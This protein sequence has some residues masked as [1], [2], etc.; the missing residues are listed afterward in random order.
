MK[1]LLV[2]LVPCLI[3]LGGCATPKELKQ[4]LAAPS[5]VEPIPVPDLPA[6]EPPSQH[7]APRSA[8]TVMR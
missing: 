2:A 4:P 8:S 6:Y 3:L 1:Y 7:A 5:F